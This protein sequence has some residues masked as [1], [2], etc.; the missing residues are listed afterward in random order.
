MRRGIRELREKV[1]ADL[2]SNRFYEEIGCR[3]M[4]WE[5]SERLCVEKEEFLAFADLLNRSDRSEYE[6]KAAFYYHQYGREDKYISYLEAHLGKQGKI[7]A[8]L[9]ECYQKQGNI[10][11]ARKT[12]RQG[13]EQCRDELTDLF[14]WLLI[15]ARRS[16]DKESYK[17]LYASAKRR[18]GADIKRID[19]ALES[20]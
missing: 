1:L 17:K 11:S 6:R 9:A 3:E 2:V 7:Y 10:D 4:M 19:K 18:R 12:A 16:G 15:D 5:L 13:L 14:I 20:A 8:A